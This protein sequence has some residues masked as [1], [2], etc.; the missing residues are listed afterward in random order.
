MSLNR[1]AAST[2]HPAQRL[3]RDLGGL[4]GGAAR[5][6]DVAIAAQLAVLGQVAAGLAH[7]PHRRAIHGLAPQRAEET[8]ELTTRQD[9]D[10][11]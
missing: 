9:T 1:I 6:E 3:Q 2:R 11:G 5:L 8:I 7:E 4:L 10:P